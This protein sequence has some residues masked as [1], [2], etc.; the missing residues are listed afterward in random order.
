MHYGNPGLP[1]RHFL[2]YPR[3]LLIYHPLDTTST[4]KRNGQ[5]KVSTV[6]RW[7][8]P[9]APRNKPPDPSSSPFHTLRSPRR[10]VAVHPRTCSSRP[11]PLPSLPRRRS[12]LVHLLALVLCLGLPPP[13]PSR[14]LLTNAPASSSIA[15]SPPLAPSP[16]P[17]PR[18][19]TLCPLQIRL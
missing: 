3:Q 8:L 12:I 7:R 4:T 9:R 14:L 15:G 17:H 18:D 5:K 11:L 16:P 19:M 13:P 1:K 6:S 10:C 2:G